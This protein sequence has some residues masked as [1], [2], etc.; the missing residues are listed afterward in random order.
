MMTLGEELR[1]DLLQ[2]ANQMIINSF[3]FRLLELFLD[4]LVPEINKKS[5][6]KRKF[7]KD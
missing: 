2:I 3:L 1:K 6:N 4:L 5:T 7:Y